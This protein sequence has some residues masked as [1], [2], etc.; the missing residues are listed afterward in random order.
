[1]FFRSIKEKRNRNEKIDY[2]I[3][4]KVYFKRVDSE[5][6]LKTGVASRTTTRRS[7]HVGVVNFVGVGGNDNSDHVG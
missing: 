1:M 4:V 7:R 3:K 6:Q 5:L 2:I